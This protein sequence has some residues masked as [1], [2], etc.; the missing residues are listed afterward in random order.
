M[1]CVR[2]DKYGKHQR[3]IT[4]YVEY[5]TRSV[6]FSLS[7]P[8]MPRHFIISTV[9]LSCSLGV[10]N[11]LKIE[12]QLAIVSMLGLCNANVLLLHFP[13]TNFDPEYIPSFDA[14][15]SADDRILIENYWPTADLY[16]SRKSKVCG[17]ESLI[18]RC[19][20]HDFE[21]ARPKIYGQ[22]QQFGVT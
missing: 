15:N 19:M 18:Q 3:L 22:W 21:K 20:I 5:S 4:A 10:V 16:D 7:I 17:C 1:N 2:A 8:Q 14:D 6:K 12:Y 11:R 13:K 9:D